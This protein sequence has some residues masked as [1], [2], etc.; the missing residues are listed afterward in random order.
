MSS[1]SNKESKRRKK[2]R[3]ESERRQQRRQ[4]VRAIVVI[5]P[6]HSLQQTSFISSL[7]YFC[8]YSL[9]KKT[10][11]LHLFFLLLIAK[12]FSIIHF[13][14]YDIFST[15]VLILLYTNKT[16]STSILFLSR[17]ILYP[18]SLTIRFYFC[19]TCNG[20]KK[21]ET[22]KKKEEKIYNDNADDILSVPTSDRQINSKMKRKKL[23]I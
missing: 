20:Y 11:S 22:K 1:T 4:A 12:Y 16:I 5:A 9:E 14:D 13:F 3:R 10:V 15:I 17:H 21:K 18:F 7:S 2:E 8:F 23:Y 19:K 6:C